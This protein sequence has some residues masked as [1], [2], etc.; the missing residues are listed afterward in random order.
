MEGVHLDSFII[1]IFGASGSG[2]T[3]LMEMLMVS[4]GQY[5]VHEKALIDRHGNT[6]MLNYDALQILM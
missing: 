1:I 2:K 4:G 5:S 3:S 6:M